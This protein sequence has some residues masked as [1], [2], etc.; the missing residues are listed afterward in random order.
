LKEIMINETVILFEDE[1]CGCDIEVIKFAQVATEDYEIKYWINAFGDGSTMLSVLNSDKFR[2]TRFIPRYNISI[3][4]STID[5]V[6]ITKNWKVEKKIKWAIIVLVIFS[7]GFGCAYCIFL[8]R[9]KKWKHY[10]EECKGID[11]GKTGIGKLEETLTVEL[12]EIN[13]SVPDEPNSVFDINIEFSEREIP[14]VALINSSIKQPAIPRKENESESNSVIPPS[15]IH[16]GFI[17][18]S[19]DQTWKTRLL[20]SKPMAE[21]NFYE[22]KF[23]K[24]I[25]KGS[26]GTVWLGE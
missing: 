25:G 22:L 3:S 26:F 15:A 4:I 14:S 6:L 9:R 23:E 8:W 1:C 5:A 7:A 13:T 12:D 21:I 20:E 2:R 16:E 11:L 19:A 10:G 24:E 17:S 18:D